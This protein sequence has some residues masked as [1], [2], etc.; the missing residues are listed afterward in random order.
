MSQAV[1]FDMDGVIIDSEP[2]HKRVFTKLAGEHGIPLTPEVITSYIGRSPVAQWTDL[3][4]KYHF[5]EDPEHIV[6]EQMERYLSYL[7]HNHPSPMPGLPSLLEY[8]HNRNIP[9]ALA[10]SNTRKVVEAV[11]ELLGISQ[12]FMKRVSGQDVVHAKPAPDVFLSAA[13]KLNI[14]AEFC[15]VIED[16]EN[17]VKA[18]K[19]AGM[20]CVGLQIPG[21]GDQELSQAD[22]VVSSLNELEAA[23][24]NGLV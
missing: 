4:A 8:L 7:A 6:E 11:P 23:F 2:I 9:M 1:I 19:T 21:A 24:I 20:R 12:Y 17:G 3:K 18:A 22:I 15:I 5:D 14:A 16:A 13:Q 10:S